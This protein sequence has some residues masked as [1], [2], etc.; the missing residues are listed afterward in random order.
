MLPAWS[1]W[2]LA[3]IVPQSFFIIGAYTVAHDAVHRVASRNHLLNELMLAGCGVVFLFDPILYRRIHLQHHAHT[4]DG[5][6][7]PDRFTFAGNVLG[8]VARS[9]VVIV[10][11]YAYAVR[12]LWSR[13]RMRKHVICAPFVPVVIG[14]TFAGFG[15]IDIF[16]IAWAVPV[17]LANGVLALLLSSLT[18][19]HE[20]DQTKNLDVPRWV[21]WLLGNGHLHL[22]HHRFPRVP[23]HRLPRVWREHVSSARC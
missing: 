7:D 21:G 6:A 13:P 12:A 5:A 9:S 22:A 4:H 23:W 18:H 8:R 17:V 16:A 15:R 14:L 19:D 3:C 11:Y 20:R 10:G 2:L 1:P